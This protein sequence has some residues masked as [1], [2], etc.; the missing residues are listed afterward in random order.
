MLRKASKKGK[1]ERKARKAS[2]TLKKEPLLEP[3]F[4]GGIARVQ[5]HRLVLTH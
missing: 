3:R 1:Q 5:I 4:E 2:K